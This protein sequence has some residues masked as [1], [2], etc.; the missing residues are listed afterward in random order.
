MKSI[1]LHYASNLAG[2]GGA[3]AAPNDE[4]FTSH[5]LRS[6]MSLATPEGVKLERGHVVPT[7]CQLSGRRD[8]QMT[9][10]PHKTN[11]DN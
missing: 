4:T 10:R 11:P 9:G 1:S 7:I 2:R 8:R 6:P 3:L 5:T